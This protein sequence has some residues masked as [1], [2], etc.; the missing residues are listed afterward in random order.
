[1]IGLSKKSRLIQSRQRLDEPRQHGE[2]SLYDHRHRDSAPEDHFRIV[3]RR[4]LLY[5]D[6]ALAF[7]S[8]EHNRNE[9][10]DRIDPGGKHMPRR[11]D[12]GQ[13]VL[14]Y[15]VLLR[16]DTVWANGAGELSMSI[17]R[18]S[19]NLP[20]ASP[21]P[22]VWRIS[23]EPMVSVIVPLASGEAE[24]RDLIA[25]LPQ[26]FEIILARGGTRATSM[27]EAAA[28][29][30][31]RYLWFIH[32]DTILAPDAVRAL[33]RL[34]PRED[35]ILYFDLRFDSGLLMRLTELCVH[36]R[37]RVLGLPFGDQ[38]LCLSRQ[39]FSTLGAYDERVIHGEDHLLVR[40]AHRAGIAV[41]PVGATLVTSARK[42]RRNGW[43]RTTWQH[44]CLTL[45]QMVQ[46]L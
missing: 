21:V 27:N 30:K 4:R 19:Q 9:N 18:A 14:A 15:R 1:L 6:A 44:L 7:S 25:L 16:G 22:E 5:A 26:D 28:I 45:R 39:T 34:L 11:R 29:V 40:K 12:D 33:Q 35:A 37:S 17:S 31:G 42:Y 24:P 20:M 38:A 13:D 2:L 23:E 32:A 41:A 43:F 8:L 46:P 3:V 10:R 36:F